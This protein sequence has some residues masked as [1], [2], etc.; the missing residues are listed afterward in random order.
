MLPPGTK[1]GVEARRTSGTDCVCI[2]AF[3]GIE[4]RERS[5]TSPSGITVM[6]GDVP[7]LPWVLGAGVTGAEV[8]GTA[9]EVGA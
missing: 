5:E 3:V 9:V 4:P 8:V 2:G 6:A 7:S 1:R